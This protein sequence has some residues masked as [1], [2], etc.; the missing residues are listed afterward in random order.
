MSQM[1]FDPVVTCFLK[2]TCNLHKP[3]N[4]FLDFINGHFMGNFPSGWRR[5][6]GRRPDRKP[7]IDTFHL[8]PTMVNLAQNF[9]S[10][11]MDH[12]CNKSKTGNTFFIIPVNGPWRALCS[13]VSGDGFCDDQANTPFCSFGVIIGHPLIR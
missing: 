11:F 5:N 8:P 2:V 13:W 7:G 4:H 6:G 12:R 1:D 3:L 10:M 9:C